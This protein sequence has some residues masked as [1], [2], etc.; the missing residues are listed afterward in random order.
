M[1]GHYPINTGLAVRLYDRLR[2]WHAVAAAM[3]RADGTP[4]T[5]GAILAAVRRADLLGHHPRPGCDSAELR[6]R[7]AA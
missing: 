2:S 5:A 1:S 6:P 7:I 4:F 3:P